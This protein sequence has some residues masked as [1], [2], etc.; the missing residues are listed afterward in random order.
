[1]RID[2]HQHFWNF[3]PVRDRWITEEMS[4]LKRNFLPEDL[5]PELRANHIDGAVAVQ[6]D[7][8]EAETHFLLDLVEKHP[9]ILGVVGWVDLSAPDIAARLADYRSS[10]RL[11]GFRHIVQS[12]PDDRFVLR[13]DFCR[14]IGALEQFDFTYDILIYPRQLPAAIELAAKFPKQKFVLDHLAKPEIRSRK[15]EPWSAQLR[16]LARSPNVFCKLSGLVTE[17]DWHSWRLSDIAPFLDVAF[18]AFGPGRLMFGSDWPVCL[19][20][21]S[22]SN[23]FHLL[24]AYVTDHAPSQ[25]D[26]IFGMN[27]WTFYGLHSSTAASSRNLQPHA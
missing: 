7:P 3:D 25:M 13:P 21:G 20:A 17:A 19:V 23:A 18:E 10:P 9:F 6:A 26:A 24:E 12:E 8:S 5:G 1:M 2:A 16:E 11:R 4:V 14:G 27:A 22:Y 15:L